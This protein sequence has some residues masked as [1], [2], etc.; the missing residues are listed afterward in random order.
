MDV[1]SH[2]EFQ[3][4]SHLLADWELG[5]NSK[6]AIGQHDTSRIPCFRNQQYGED[7]LRDTSAFIYL[8]KQFEEACVSGSV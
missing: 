6:S 3:K 8:A 5:L 2:G 7:Y 1:E 4:Q